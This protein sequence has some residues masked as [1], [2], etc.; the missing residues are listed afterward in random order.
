LDGPK[1]YSIK[2]HLTANQTNANIG[3][4]YEW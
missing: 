4:K 1:I 3:F 2:T